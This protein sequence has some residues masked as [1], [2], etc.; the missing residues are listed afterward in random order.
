MSIREFLQKT[1]NGEL[2][3][4]QQRN[5][6][7]HK[8]VNDGH[9]LAD[10]VH[11][12]LKQMSPV[13]LLPDAIDIVGTGGSGLD[14]INTSTLTALLLASDGVKVA[15]HGNRSASGKFGSFDLLEA[16]GIPIELEPNDLE[17]TYREHHVAFLYAKS[18]HPVMR[19]FAEVRTAIGK[20]TFFNFLG[21][22]LSPVQA[23]QQV[24]G[25]YDRSTMRVVAETV[26]ALGRERVLVVHGS[27]GLDEI[28]VTG[29]T[30]VIELKNGVL[31]EY[32]I[33]SKTFGITAR[34][35]ADDIRGG[36]GA[37]N[38]AIAHAVLENRATPAQT[39]LV[40]VNTAAGLYV[41]GK[42]DSLKDGYR[43]A[44][45]IMRSKKAAEL[46]GLLA[47][48]PSIL[49]QIVNRRSKDADFTA[50]KKPELR[51]VRKFNGGLIAE[52]KKASPSR[53]DIQ[54]DVDVVRQAR[55]YETSG[56][57]AI[58]VVTEPHFFG[59]SLSD[60]AKVRQSTASVPILCKDFINE[61]AQINAAYAAGADMILLIAAVLKPGQFKTLLKH[62]KSLDL[63]VLTEVHTELELAMVLEGGADII[64]VNAR[65]LHDFSIDPHL[66]SRLQK[67]IPKGVLCIAESGINNF[68][69]IP[70]GANGWLVGSSIMQHPFPK[71]KV[72]ELS[73][74][75]LLKLCGIRD[76]EA[77]K[78][79]EQLSVDLIGLN[80]VPRSRRKISVGLAKQI[81]SV[82]KSTLVVGIFENQ[83]IS[84]VKKISDAV[85]LDAVQLSGHEIV[86][87]YSDIAPIISTRT[88]H[89]TPTMGA[90]M[91]IVDNA[92]GG[93]G[94]TI[95]PEE[96][97]VYE[98]SLVAGGVDLK[99]AR[100]LLIKVKPLGIDTASGIETDGKTDHDKI[101][102]FA[103]LIH[104]TR[105]TKI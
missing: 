45:I 71:L 96:L 24:I 44:K 13:P 63:Q 98:P 65:N 50:V 56:A 85:K 60:I 25:V 75:P 59:G 20:P 57:S 22:L 100:E 92:I 69:D 18:F 70:A 30:H 2:S 23:R 48:A 78:L 32:D 82:C 3:L 6:L 72:K 34:Y 11:Y 8:V 79:C 4:E 87:E 94:I 7:E 52:I 37:V 29:P 99:I 31:E 58:S 64:G 90:F 105:Y 16:L 40:L 33:T 14:T 5:Y 1:I 86:D 97:D 12:L 9:E 95:D 54:P 39:D 67:H 42:A 51:S 83:S 91:E 46:A 27:D 21:P 36:D 68:K 76:V 81:R 88:A 35:G 19:H 101:T 66:F 55:L 53:G 47:G 17:R 10:A 62:A 28:T 103:E 43:Q 80:F 26:Q 73:G 93:S 61:T 84:E 38:V 104:K 49:Q 102:A 15:K 41:A 89:E 74:Q 77:A